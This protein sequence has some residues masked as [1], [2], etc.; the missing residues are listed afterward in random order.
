MAGLPARIDGATY[1]LRLEATDAYAF[2]HL[3]IVPKT[4][5]TDAH[6]AAWMAS[7]GCRDQALGLLDT[8]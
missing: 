3:T 7:Q 5:P 2:V 1:G 8:L 4:L 6:R